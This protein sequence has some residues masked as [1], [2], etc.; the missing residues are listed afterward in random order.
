MNDLSIV[1]PE[2]NGAAQ[3]LSLS[4]TSNSCL[5]REGIQM[6]LAPY[7]PFHLFGQYAAQPFPEELRFPPENHIALIDS[8]IGYDLVSQWIRYWRAVVPS[9]KIILLELTNNID[10]IVRSIK[11]GICGYTL[12]NATP[13][14]VATTIRL[15]NQGGAIC[16]PEVTAHLF[17]CVSTMA[18]HDPNLPQ[19]RLLLTAREHEVLEYVV[20]GYSN[21]EIA[22]KLVIELR[23]VKQHVHN[24]LA[25]LNLKNRIQT[26]R[27][28]TE[29]GWFALS[30][31]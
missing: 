23:T 28:A 5:L 4:I 21:K 10:I 25:K 13:Q 8:G 14:E 6:I 15:V 3:A 20:K 19:L 30:H 2:H 18:H 22:A 11:A 31:E 27:I 12:E 16:S 9:S 29:Q 7:L 26:V 17:A 24:I 1:R